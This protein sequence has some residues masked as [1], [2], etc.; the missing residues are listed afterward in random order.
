MA[1]AAMTVVYAWLSIRW[2]WWVSLPGACA[3]FGGTRLLLE[4]VP[5]QVLPALGAVIAS[6]I[7]A[8]VMLPPISGTDSSG[9]GARSDVTPRAVSTVA[10]VLLVTGLADRLG[11]NVSGVFAAFPIPLMT[12]AE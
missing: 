2:G 10:V 6:V 4:G 1:V 5:W 12:L 11:P 8:R 3:A 9:S 7:V